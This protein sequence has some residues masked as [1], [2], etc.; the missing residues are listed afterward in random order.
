MGSHGEYILRQKETPNGG[1]SILQMPLVGTHK[2]DSGLLELSRKTKVGSFSSL[3][4]QPA[5]VNK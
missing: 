5:T 3:F 2:G 4:K 1:N